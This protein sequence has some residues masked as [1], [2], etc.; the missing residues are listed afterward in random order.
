MET[1]SRILRIYID[2]IGG[3]VLLSYICPV[4]KTE[5]SSDSKHCKNCGTWLLD[6]NYPPEIKPKKPFYCRIPGYRSGKWWKKLIASVFYVF[7]LLCIFIVWI[8]IKNPVTNQSIKQ[9][10]YTVSV[11]GIGKI[12]GVC[13]N[14]VGVAIAS[15]QTAK[16]IEHVQTEGEFYIIRVVF[17][18]YRKSPIHAY[19][20]FGN[21]LFKIIDSSGR[22]F[23]YSPDG[24]E[25]FYDYKGLSIFG[26]IG[27]SY[28]NPGI[29]AS[30]YIVFDM[31]PRLTN[32]KLQ[33][34]S[35][36]I[37]NT[38]TLPLEVIK[39]D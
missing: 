16:N 23:T 31:P 19:G 5:N 7:V 10:P 27:G 35:T 33:I 39:V 37:G 2:W 18:N 13:V 29:T 25:A 36:V 12:K 6:T 3:G 4:C 21:P 28:I 30:D 26:N 24:Q 32:L 20:S 17:A 38:V 14:N 34:Q 11:Q 9:I 15:I 8:A 22:E 1:C